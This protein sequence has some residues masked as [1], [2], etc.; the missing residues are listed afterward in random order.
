M[1]HNG[2]EI[3]AVKVR[4]G[5][6]DH[7]DEHMPITKLGVQHWP[8]P[9]TVKADGGIYRRIEMSQIPSGNGLVVRGVVYEWEQTENWE[10]A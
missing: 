2:V 6:Y 7:N 10:S 4:G 3:I 5:P 9:E 8:P 1:I